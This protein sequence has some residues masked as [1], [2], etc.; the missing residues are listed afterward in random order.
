V[1]DVLNLASGVTHSNSI[2]SAG[3]D[4]QNPVVLHYEPQGNAVDQVPMSP[5]SV[6]EIHAEYDVEFGHDDD[7]LAITLGRLEERHGLDGFAA[8]FTTD[9]ESFL[10]SVDADSEAPGTQPYTDPSGNP[11]LQLADTLWFGPATTWPSQLPNY[12]YIHFWHRLDG[13]LLAE[14]IPGMGPEL[15]GDDEWAALFTSGHLAENPYITMAISENTNA[16]FAPLEVDQLGTERPVNT[17][18]DIGA[19]EIP[20]RH[21]SVRPTRGSRRK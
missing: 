9:F 12:P 14:H 2:L 19:I 7:F 1:A 16:G 18:C 15:L 13:A 4:A 17:L 6:N 11:I 20:G 5:Y 8:D 21:P 10:E 3:V